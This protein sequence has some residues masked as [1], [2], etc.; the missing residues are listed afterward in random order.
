M[1]FFNS[2]L[3]IPSA[4]SYNITTSSLEVSLYYNCSSLGNE[5]GALQLPLIQGG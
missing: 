1:I 3:T 4:L 5:N 2:F